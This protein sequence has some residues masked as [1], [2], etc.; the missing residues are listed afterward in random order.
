MLSAYNKCLVSSAVEVNKGPGHDVKA[1][2]PQYRHNR[3]RFSDLSLDCGAF[4]CVLLTVA[5]QLMSLSSVLFKVTLSLA[6]VSI[7]SFPP[8]QPVLH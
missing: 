1:H 6:A 7:I 4:L 2:F 8:Q 3:I 5:F